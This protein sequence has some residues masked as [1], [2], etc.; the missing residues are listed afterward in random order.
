MS[1]DA[2][3]VADRLGEVDERQ[4][5]GLETTPKTRTL[6]DLLR[7]MEPQLRR[8]FP[9]TIDVG[10]FIRLAETSL[11]TVPRLLECDPTTVMAGF[12]QAAQLGVEIDAVRGQAYLIPRKN[13]RT[14]K[15]EAS[16]QLGYHGL[17]DI[18]G[19][20]GVTVRVRAVREADEFQHE[21][22]LVPVLRHVPFLRGDRGAAYAYYS[23]ASFS[24]ERPAEFLVM[25]LP[26]VE[27]VRDRFGQKKGGKVVGPWVDHFDA[28]AFKTVIIR[29]LNYLPLPVE[30]LDA[31]R[32]D[33]ASPLDVANTFDAPAPPELP[34]PASGAD[35]ASA[36]GDSHPGPAEGQADTKTTAIVDAIEADLDGKKKA[37][38]VPR[39]TVDDAPPPEN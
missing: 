16:F 10:R 14:N 7:D 26:E 18:A 9:K 2:T 27:Q 34:P 29:L 22:G 21:D 15:M 31:I 3:A 25:T 35:A 20:S 1:K 17:I 24:D 8:A 4:K 11:R 36:S 32:D 5:A 12:M 39:D 37:K 30:V 38:P 13:N 6:F 23:I 28:M 33:D 19:R